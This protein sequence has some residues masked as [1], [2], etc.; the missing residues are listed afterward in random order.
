MNKLLVSAPPPTAN[1]DLHLG[2][3]S[4]PFLRA[5][6]LYKYSK[7]RGRE[8]YCIN[9]ADEHQSYVAFMAEKLGQTPLE[10]VDR[11]SEGIR[12]A[13]QMADCHFDVFMRPSR[14]PEHQKLTQEIFQSL[15]DNGKLITREEPA[16]FCEKC[17]QYLFEVYVL[18]KCPHCNAD[19]C[20]NACEGCG[21]PNNCI[22]LKDPVCNRCR[23]VPETRSFTRLYFPLSAYEDQLRSYYQS[24]VMNAR[25]RKICEAMLADGLPDIVVGHPAGWGIPVPVAGFEG[26]RIY[27]WFEVATGLL[28]ATQLLSE[29]VGLNEGWKEFW[30]ADD[31]DVVQFCGFDNGYFYGIL[32]PALLL[33]YDPQIKLPAAIMLNE[34]YR[35]DGSKFSTSRNHAIWCRELLQR[36]SLDAV[37]FYLALCGPETEQTNFT[38]AD[39]EQTIQRELVDGWQDWLRALGAE[40]A[41]EYDGVVPPIDGVL[42]KEQRDF[43]NQIERL[44]A[45]AFNAYEV[46]TFS[47]RR[48]AS[49]LLELGRAARRF[50]ES[51]SRN[52]ESAQP[53]DI[54]L[55]LAAAKTLAMLSSPIMPGFGA[56]LWRDLG[57]T[58]QVRWADGVRWLPAGTRVNNLDQPYFSEPARAFSKAAISIPGT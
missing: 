6:I 38:M 58:T 11:Y 16:L 27:V 43:Y 29:K 22:D 45:E 40:L 55:E 50:S 52:N 4:G 2:H 36:V 12:T 32:I 23:S 51:Q 28:G 24:V 5:D 54:A 10:T 44:I 48:A 53:T 13:F 20:G 35:L 3:L 57:D 21:R 26:Q 47:P 46:A 34:F 56:R 18:G 1:G 7:L 8:V 37:R 25:L 41:T 14:T 31:V 30:R 49:V 39:F 17:E 9:G 42:T 33:A 19:S 15:Y